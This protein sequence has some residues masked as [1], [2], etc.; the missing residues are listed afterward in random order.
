MDACC[1]CPGRRKWKKVPHHWRECEEYDPVNEICARVYIVLHLRSGPR[2]PSVAVKQM[3]IFKFFGEVSNEALWRLG[4][5]RERRKTGPASTCT[6]IW[7]TSSNSLVHF[8]FFPRLWNQFLKGSN[9]WQLTRYSK[10]VTLR[11]TVLERTERKQSGPT[12]TTLSTI[13]P[14]NYNLA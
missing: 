11:V 8:N 6:S 7:P 4:V 1:F 10:K 3:W 5:Y 13:W 9:G 12:S 2:G 14:I